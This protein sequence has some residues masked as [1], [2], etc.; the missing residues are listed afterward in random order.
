L[1]SQDLPEYL[2]QIRAAKAQKQLDG[3]ATSMPLDYHPLDNPKEW[4]AQHASQIVMM[5]CIFV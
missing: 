3:N 4:C 1:A 2:Q 5:A